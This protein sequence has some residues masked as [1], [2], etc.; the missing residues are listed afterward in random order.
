V[1]LTVLS[2]SAAGHSARTQADDN[3]DQ[4]TWRTQVQ[5]NTLTS[6]LSE[7]S[8]VIPLGISAIQ[9][10]QRLLPGV[11]PLTTIRAIG[12]V[13]LVTVVV[14]SNVAHAGVQLAPPMCGKPETRVRIPWPFGL[15]LISLDG[16]AMPADQSP[17]NPMGEDWG[18]LVAAYAATR[19]FQR[20]LHDTS[21]EGIEVSNNGRPAAI[22]IP[23]GGDEVDGLIHRGEARSARAGTETLLAIR[24]VVSTTGSQD[25]IEDSRG[26]W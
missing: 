11:K 15:T 4:S 14:I 5:R 1:L 9:P 8:F 10:A 26:Q 16:V 25:L 23:I 22:I 21:G 2:V 7:L 6:L 12:L 19:T 24:R 17:E 18:R 20:V 3:T 13:V